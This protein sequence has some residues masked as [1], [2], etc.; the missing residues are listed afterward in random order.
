MGA[1]K[2]DSTHGQIRAA[3]LELAKNPNG[4]RAADITGFPAYAVA[5]QLWEM[6]N[7]GQL[8]GVRVNG[9]H[10]RVFATQEMADAWA[11]KNP[12][13]P[14]TRELKRAKAQARTYKLRG[15]AKPNLTIVRRGPWPADAQ[16]VITEKTKITKCPGFQGDP[17]FT[18]PPDFVG[19]FTRQW[20]ELRAA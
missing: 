2:P 4:I 10:S 11:A 5:T 9:K 13:K 18:P 17:R 20:R 1:F 8:F 16:P 15:T 3:A 12:P 6:K 7:R 19:E 14:T